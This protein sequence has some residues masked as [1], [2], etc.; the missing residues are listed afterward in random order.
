[1]MPWVDLALMLQVCLA[2]LGICSI[3]CGFSNTFDLLVFEQCMI[4]VC[5]AYWSLWL[6]PTCFHAVMWL[7]HHFWGVEAL[8][9]CVHHS[10]LSLSAFFS[11]SDPWLLRLHVFLEGLHVLVK[12]FSICEPWLIVQAVSLFLLMACSCSSAEP[13]MD[14]VLSLRDSRVLAARSASPYAWGYL[15]LELV[16]TKP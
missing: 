2:M 13:C 11:E 4:W 3:V 12:M 9:H 1:M 15:G 8:Y 10:K 5:G 7:F 14:L 6:A 16:C